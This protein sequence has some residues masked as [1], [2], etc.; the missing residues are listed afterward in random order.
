MKNGTG[1]RENESRSKE[2]KE[3][4]LPHEAPQTEKSKCDIRKHLK[5]SIHYNSTEM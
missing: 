5:E 1:N 4:F 2:E 3:S